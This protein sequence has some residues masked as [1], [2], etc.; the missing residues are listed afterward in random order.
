MNTSKIIEQRKIVPIAAMISA[1]KSNLLNVLFNINFLQCG[2]GIATRFVNILRYNPNIDSPR[3]YHLKIQKN[4]KNDEEYVFLKDTKYEIKIGETEIKKEN[5]RI[6]EELKNKKNAFKYEDIFYITEVKDVEFIKDKIYLKN[7]DFCDIPGLS[8][9]QEDQKN[10]GKS[11]EN[12]KGTN[13]N[14][15]LDSK[16]K[17]GEKMFGI[18]VYHP[19]RA[20]YNYNKR[21]LEDEEKKIEIDEKKKTISKKKKNKGMEEKEDSV[22]YETEL[23]KNTYI[24]EIFRI[25]KSKID[26]AII[27]LSYENYKLHENYSIITK[28]YK[29]LKKDITNCLVILNKIDLSSNPKRDIDECKALF[30]KKFPNCKTFNLNLNT[31]IPLSTYQLQNELLMKKSYEHLL[32][33]HFYNYLKIIRAQKDLGNSYEKTFIDHLRNILGKIRGINKEEIENKIK[34]LNN[35]SED[36]TIINKTITKFIEEMNNQ[37]TVDGIKLGIE[38]EEIDEN[39]EDD[40]DLDP[41]NDNND[42]N[43]IKALDIMKIFYIYQ[44]ESKYLPPFSEETIKLFNYFKMTYIKKIIPKFDSVKLNHK[45]EINKGIIKALKEFSKKIKDFKID[46]T[47]IKDLVNEIQKTIEYLKTYN[48]IFIPFLGALKSGKTTIINGIIGK[49]ILPTDI[50]TKKGII[51]RYSKNEEI[52]LRKAFFKSEKFLDKNKYFFQAGHVI[53]KGEEQVKE[54]LKG[55][56]YFINENDEDSF[57][58]LR[59]K[60]KLFDEIGLNDSLKEMIYLIDFPGYGTTNSIFEKQI[61]KQV[62]SICNT[63]IFVLKNSVIKDNNTKKT[64]NLIFSESKDQKK[65]LASKFLRSSLFVLNNEIS[66]TT[67]SNDLD[68]AKNEI[69]SIL[70]INNSK[71]IN[72]CFFNAKYYLNYCFNSDYYSNVGNLIDIEYKNYYTNK[73]KLYTNPDS[74]KLTMNSSFCDFFYTEMYYKLKDFS[75]YKN[76][77]TLKEQTINES[78]KEE[79]DKKFEKIKETEDLHDLSKYENNIKKLLSF[80]VQ[81]I[82][83]LKTLKESNIKQFQGKFS[84]QI[85][86]YNRIMQTE[87]KI[88]VAHIIELLDLFFKSDYEQKKKDSNEIKN[89]NSNTE[90]VLNELNKLIEN[91]KSKIDEFINNYRENIKN[92]LEKKKEIIEEQLKKK[93]Y[94]IIL[95]EINKEMIS[96]LENFNNKIKDYLDKN[97]EESYKYFKQAKEYIEGFAKEKSSYLKLEKKLKQYISNNIGD[98]EKD[99]EKEIFEEIKNSCESSKNIL[100]K[101]GFKDWF[102]SLFSSKYYLEKIID[103]MIE[104]FLAKINSIFEM[105]LENTNVYINDLR[106][107][108]IHCILF[109]TLEFDDEQL[110]LWNELKMAYKETREKII[111]NIY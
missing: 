13:N 27:L 77:Q 106:K 25:L 94:S 24:S 28:L 92:T 1:G 54:T 90:T 74:I 88:K 55:I 49:N 108:I 35:N 72:L 99:L 29:V 61:Y 57:Y 12:T 20:I 63:F 38:K 47:K 66:Q 97:E 31:F 48:V 91:N 76:K 15:D 98:I 46:N 14:N 96:N 23:E 78:I 58:Y 62:L 89:F 40:F 95:E 5:K 36:I 39:E 53:C 21:N 84:L 11:N 67:N 85:N 64:I 32:R 30:M 50:N 4:D 18:K 26:G 37:Y 59:T 56:N 102:Y 107:K 109:V 68:N 7:H 111:V 104:T 6:N 82:S 45:T 110:K 81:N 86:N 34:E 75:N 103:M 65:E 83:E 52:T 73:T 16:I 105:L 100:F 17:M 41:T 33:Y 51:I 101:K 42:I 22:Y 10:Q 79:I 8:E 9:C 60:I 43:S 19:K 2:T 71:N 80:C 93:N 70:N 69:K 44:K 3:F 87:L